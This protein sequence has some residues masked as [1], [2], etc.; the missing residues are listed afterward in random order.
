MKTHNW[1]TQAKKHK[2]ENQGPL[3]KELGLVLVEII[4]VIMFCLREPGIASFT[5]NNER[6]DTSHVFLVTWSLRPC[7]TRRS[8]LGSDCMT[9][10]VKRA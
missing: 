3:K 8:I 1:D 5:G 10:Y 4:A 7:R 2:G 9:K 6:L